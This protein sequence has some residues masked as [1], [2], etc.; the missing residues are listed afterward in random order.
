MTRE[1]VS[2]VRA[3]L[4]E[5]Y[6][7]AEITTTR[8]FGGLSFTVEIRGGRFSCQIGDEDSL[9]LEALAAGLPAC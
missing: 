7:S 4:R 5:A 8:I 9:I 3:L 2:R 1:A 6:P